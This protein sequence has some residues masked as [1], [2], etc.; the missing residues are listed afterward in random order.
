VHGLGKKGYKRRRIT[1][2]KFPLAI[3]LPVCGEDLK[4]SSEVQK[5]ENKIGQQETKAVNDST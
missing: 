1:E 4:A 5:K 2:R 3:D